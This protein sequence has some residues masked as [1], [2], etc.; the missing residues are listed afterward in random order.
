MDTC[1]E[2]HTGTLTGDDLAGWQAT[3]EEPAT[4]DWNGWTVCKAGGWSQGPAFLQQLGPAARRARTRSVR[5][6]PTTCTG[7][8]RARKLAMAD[9][10]AWYGDAAPTSSARRRCSPTATTTNGAR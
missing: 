10:E 3:Y 8:S 2:R 1:G 4:Y 6:R 9:R 7:S 5:L